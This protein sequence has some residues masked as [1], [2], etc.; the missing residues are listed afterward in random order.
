MS[1][2]EEDP[3]RSTRTLV[4]KPALSQMYGQLSSNVDAPA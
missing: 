2:Q 1:R 3:S 4:V